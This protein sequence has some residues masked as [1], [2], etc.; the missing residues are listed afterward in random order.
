MKNEAYEKKGNGKRGL[1]QRC[2]IGWRLEQGVGKL[3]NKNCKLWMITVEKR[4]TWAYYF[5]QKNHVL[6]TRNDFFKIL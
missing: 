1:G 3:R 5:N 2:E 4:N 6:P